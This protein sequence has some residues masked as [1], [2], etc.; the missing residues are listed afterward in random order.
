MTTPPKKMTRKQ[1]YD[2]YAKTKNQTPQGPA[3][4][5]TQNLTEMV[6]VRFE[7]DVPDEVRRR[8]RSSST[9]HRPP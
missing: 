9:S 3:R 8:D 6:P 7:A 4:P 1:E 5:R 2:H